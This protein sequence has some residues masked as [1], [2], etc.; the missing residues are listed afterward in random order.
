MYLT[1]AISLMLYHIGMH[2]K[3]DV[4]SDLITVRAEESDLKLYICYITK[5][6]FNL[7]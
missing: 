1:Q 3:T 5:C 6:S 4:V 7:L 2:N